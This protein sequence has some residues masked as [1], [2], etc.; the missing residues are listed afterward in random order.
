M[1]RLIALGL[2]S[3]FV[4]VSAGSAVAQA[5]PTPAPEHE[6][7]QR[8]VGVWDAKVKVLMGPEAMES[9]GTE[10]VSLLGG[11]WQVSTFEG[12]FMGMPFTGQ[13][14]LGWDPG[15][16]KYVNGWIDSTSP[17]LTRGEATYD[18]ATQ[19]LSGTMEGPGMDGTPQKMEQVIKWIDDDNRVVTMRMGGQTTMEI[20]YTRKK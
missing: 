16:K 12:S 1:K 3:S 2:A 19:T 15:S 8:D 6:L 11:F 17:G 18:A 20:V 4:V 13:G 7:L 5:P 14:W 10:T 9:T